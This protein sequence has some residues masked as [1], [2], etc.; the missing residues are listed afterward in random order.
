MCVKIA[1]YYWIEWI[2]HIN[3]NL[4]QSPP[5]CPLIANIYLYRVFINWMHISNVITFAELNHMHGRIIYDNW[6]WHTHRQ[7]HR[8]GHEHTRTFIYRTQRAPKR[9]AQEDRDSLSNTYDNGWQNYKIQK[10]IRLSMVKNALVACFRWFRLGVWI[11]LFVR[12]AHKPTRMRRS[13]DSI[14]GCIS[15]QNLLCMNWRVHARYIYALSRLRRSVYVLRSSPK[16]SSSNPTMAWKQC[17]RTQ[18]SESP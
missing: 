17:A 10:V 16:S 8:H 13:C 11:N 4:T 3:L 5:F 6:Q 18:M 15:R 9:G 1:V 7:R 12:N 14:F 2:D